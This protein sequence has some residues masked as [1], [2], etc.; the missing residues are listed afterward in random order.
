MDEKLSSSEAKKHNFTVRVTRL[1]A[2]LFFG[3]AIGILFFQRS[4]LVDPIPTFLT[5]LGASGGALF[6]CW[7]G[8]V[9]DTTTP[10]KDRQF[11]RAAGLFALTILPIFVGTL[12]VRALVLQSAFWGFGPA[13]VATEFRVEGS[14][15]RCRFGR[16][17]IDLRLGPGSRLIRVAVD[18]SLKSK[19]GPARSFSGH[20]ITLD[21]QTGRWGYRRAIVPNIFDQPLGGD[22]YQRCGASSG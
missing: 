6:G 17:N 8:Y 11:R 3:L 15:G 13:M 7:I 21:V 1:S 12:L 5:F 4:Q 16:C 10:N 18:R 19:V 14:S 22:S 9:A 2:I 20:C